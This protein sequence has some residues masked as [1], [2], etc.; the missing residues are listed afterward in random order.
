MALSVTRAA[1]QAP[2]ETRT[3][4]LEREQAEKATRLRPYEPNVAEKYLALA[5]GILTGGQRTFYPYFQS[6]YSGGG[7]TLGAGYAF[8]VSSYNTVDTRGSITFSG[9]KRIE[10]EFTAPRLFKRQALLSVLGGWR[11]ATQVDFFGTGMATSPDL[12]VNY[13]FKQP[14]GQ[15]TLNVRPG[16]SIFVLN[17]GVEFTQWEQTPGSGASPSV[18]QIFTPENLAGVGAKVTYVHSLGT[19]GVDSR[20]S[21]GYARRGGFYGVTYHDYTDVDN[22][23]GFSQ[24]DY[25]AIQH[26]PL[27]RETWVLSFRGAVTTTGLKGSEQIPFFM[28]PALGGG[29]SLRGYS[30]WRFRDRH[31]MELQAEWRIMVNRF[32]D[33][34]VFYDTGKVVSD[35]ADLDFNGLRRD[36]GFGARFHGP[37]TTPLRIDLARGDEGWHFIFAAKAAF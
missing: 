18:E 36:I 7:F 3:A 34:A 19:V 37:L 35:T 17:G 24:L 6:A 15:V 12:R 32:F 16:R 21:R 22:R 28:L 10:T 13:G 29:S 25:E 1:A 5:E 31:T 26:V 23:F 11:E 14:Y 9:Y 33:T 8:P 20:V 2:P 30:S 27:V 4:A